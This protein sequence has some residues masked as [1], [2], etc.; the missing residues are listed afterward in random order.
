MSNNTSQKQVTEN[1]TK[2][3][4]YKNT[5]EI[6]ATPITPSIVPVA[7][8][9]ETGSMN[10]YIVKSTLSQVLLYNFFLI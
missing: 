7:T 8:N 10:Q 3:K 6:I 5:L 9:V 2:V 4:F 1:K